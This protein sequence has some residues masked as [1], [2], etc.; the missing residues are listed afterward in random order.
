[1]TMADHEKYEYTSIAGNGIEY[2]MERLNKK[3]EE[4]WHVVDSWLGMHPDQQ[5]K[6][7]IYLLQRR[8]L[9]PDKQ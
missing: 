4:G 6:S 8:K 2:L 9:E 3:G 5:F 7:R 1:M